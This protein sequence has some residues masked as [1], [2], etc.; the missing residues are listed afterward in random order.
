MALYTIGIYLYGFALR[1]AALLHPKAQKWVQGRQNWADHHRQLRAA[2]PKD[3]DLFWFHC[4][5]LGEF[6]QGRPL[7]EALKQRTNPPLILLTF[8]SP[9]GYEVRRN[10]PEADA[11][12]YLPL[13]TPAQARVFL[14]IWQP[15][16]AVFVK[17]EFWFNMLR[18]LQ[19]KEVPILLISGLFRPGQ[20]F[21]KPF[22]GPFRR[23][24]KGF[25]HLF[26]QNEASGQ[27]LEQAGITRYT[28]A[29]DTRID[30]VQ[31]IADGAPAIP[32]AA[33]FCQSA[34][35]LVAGSSWPEDEAY[36]L[37]Y[38]NQE[39]PAAWKVIIAPHEIAEAHL[40]RIEQ[41]LSLTVVRY[42]KVEG[43]PEKLHAARVLLIDN[44]GMLSALYQYGRIA[45]VGGG[46]KT[47]LHNTLEPIAFGLPVLFGPRYHK[48][49][50]ARYLVAQGGG[51][52]IE[53]AD[54]LSEALE[55]LQR[56][57][58][59]QEASAK[60]LQ[61]IQQNQG[62]TQKVLSWIESAGL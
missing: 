51:F 24:L 48:F 57:E 33:D 26:V 62:A 41:Q 2:L 35:V 53:N 7:I 39:L 20:V 10:Y 60:A 54:A 32:I 46:F 9:S 44:I 34:P 16:L 30:R 29:G 52:V 45:Y 36:L 37:P 25:G 31:S 22:G 27:Q 19:Q 49:E 13:D 14:E 38:I 61:Y 18:Q 4:A 6:E 3:R 15:Q 5:S 1:L 50:E 11:V 56:P 40:Q 17:Y 47:G 8:Y 23:L 58:A 28:V 59:Y 12:T 43:H 55:K 21:F 42:G